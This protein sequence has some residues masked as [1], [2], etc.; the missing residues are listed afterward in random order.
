MRLL[1]LTSAM[2]TSRAL[3]LALMACGALMSVSQPLPGTD[4][5]WNKI[6][7]L[8]GA[9]DGYGEPALS[10]SSLS[11]SESS[12]DAT[13]AL[14][15]I[16]SRCIALGA[17]DRFVPVSLEAVF[18]NPASARAALARHGSALASLRSASARLALEKLLE[19][20]EVSVDVRGVTVSGIE[21]LYGVL[22]ASC[23]QRIGA[24]E[25]TSEVAAD[26]RAAFCLSLLFRSEPALAVVAVS[27]SNKACLEFICAAGGHPS[28]NYALLQA[29]LDRVLMQVDCM[30]DQSLTK[31]AAKH[32]ADPK[33]AS[34]VKMATESTL[35]NQARVRCMRVALSCLA[36]R[37]R[38]GRWPDSLSAVE[39]LLHGG[40]PD[41]PFGAHL[42]CLPRDGRIEIRSTG[43]VKLGASA[44]GLSIK[45]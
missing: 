24:G 25:P 3:R 44:Y 19:E 42:E 32:S 5:D 27:A 40:I 2:R 12:R 20:A 22:L 17:D 7:D 21:R 14:D 16:V 36:Y 43:V 1:R 6:V 30:L 15:E 38:L 28:V 9:S 41:D 29:A 45:L 26:I 4:P 33:Q 23:A 34:A 39:P 31:V 8:Q 13:A 18:A 11:P 10:G 35:L 37:E